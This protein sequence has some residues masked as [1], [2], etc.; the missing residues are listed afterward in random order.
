MRR[1][2][3]RIQIGN[4]LWKSHVTKVGVLVL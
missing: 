1:T 4:V 2:L 3:L